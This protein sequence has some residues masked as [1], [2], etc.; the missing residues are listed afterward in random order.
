MNNSDRTYTVTEV[1]PHCESEIEMRWNTDTMG[2]KAFCPACGKRLMLCDECRHAE[3]PDPCDYDGQTDSCH[4]NKDGRY[5]ELAMYTAGDNRL[6]LT[7]DN[8]EPGGPDYEVVFDAE[9][10]RFYCF[11]HGTQSLLEALGLFFQD[12]PH[13]T[14]D[15]IVDY[16]EV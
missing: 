12:N 6:D 4:W 2:F 1:C 9:G 11:L 5:P 8:P 7:R 10:E 16:M 15:M 3:E 13:I 14:Y